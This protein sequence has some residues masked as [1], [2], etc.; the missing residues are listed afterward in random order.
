[1][2]GMN[3]DRV[4]TTCAKRAD[5]KKALGTVIVSLQRTQYDSISQLRIFA[6]IDDVMSRLMHELQI[7]VIPEQVYVDGDVFCNLPFGTDGR[8]DSM[9]SLTLDLRPGCRVRLIDQPE[10]DLARL[11]SAEGEVTGKDKQGHFIIRFGC[12]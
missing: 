2:G 7:E 4:A 10:W 11:G 5:H 8:R 3:A 6:P 1:M 12:Q 9:K